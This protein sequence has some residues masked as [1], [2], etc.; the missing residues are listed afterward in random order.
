MRKIDLNEIR[1]IQLDILIQVDKFCRENGIRYSLAYGT[2]IGAV[3][4]K[5]FIPWD[6]DIDIIM[7]R[8]DYERFLKG[9]Y[10]K[11]SYL[12]IKNYRNDDITSITWTEVIDIRTIMYAKN[13]KTSVFIDVFPIDG[14]PENNKVMEHIKETYKRRCYVI[15]KRRSYKYGKNKLKRYFKYIGKQLLYPKSRERAIREYEEY[16]FSYPFETSPNAGMLW[17]KN[18]P[19]EIMS[20]EIFK[21]YRTIEFEGHEFMCISD[22]DTILKRQYGDYME[23]PPKEKQVRGHDYPT[24]WLEKD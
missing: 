3:R 11:I 9:F 2:L 20:V 19:N 1:R 14:A 6:D 13:I 4:H 22:Y 15:R 21:N 23:F 17:S 8:P 16:V 24:F 7:P 5:G 18:D 12:G 10:G